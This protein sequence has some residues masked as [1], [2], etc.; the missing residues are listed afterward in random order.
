MNE[1]PLILDKICPKCYRELSAYFTS[2]K[3]VYYCPSCGYKKINDY[4]VKTESN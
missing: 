2:N 1:L 4:N 3:S